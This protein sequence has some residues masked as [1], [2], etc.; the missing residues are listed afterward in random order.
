MRLRFVDSA[1]R[2]NKRT[3]LSCSSHEIASLNPS[4]GMS[5]C[6]RLPVLSCGDIY[7]VII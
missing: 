2:V 1:G 6:P 4:R 3:V 5:V 7:L